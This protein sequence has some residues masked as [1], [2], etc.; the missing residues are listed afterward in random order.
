MAPLQQRL[1]TLESFMPRYQ[2]T[3]QAALRKKAL[4]EAMTMAAIGT[5]WTAKV[6]PKCRRYL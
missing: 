4:K 1:D 6:G 3:G 2:T 5:N